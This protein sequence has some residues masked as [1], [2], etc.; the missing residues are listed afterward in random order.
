[1]KAFKH[2]LAYLLVVVS[3]QLYAQTDK[4]TTAKITADKR[5]VF[6]ATSAISSS[7]DVNNLL[8]KMPGNAGGGNIN[9]SGYN[10]DLT[11]TPDSIIAYLPYYGRTYSANINSD[12]NGIKF[13]SKK[14]TYQSNKKKK[15]GWQIRIDTKDTKE[16]FRLLL[17]I[18]EKGYATLVA[19]GTNKQPITFYG[20]ISEP[21]KS[22]PD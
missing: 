9:L 12:E 20:V 6:Q 13:T 11:I 22:K 5:F 19:I 4:A 2:L 1:M 21:K 14:F 15:G 7:N 16:G 17:D 8:R 10:Y 18:S 3:A